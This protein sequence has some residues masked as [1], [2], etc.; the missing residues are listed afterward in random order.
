MKAFTSLL[1]AASLFASSGL[2]AQDATVYSTNKT[3]Y[4]W[5]VALFGLGV[6]ATVAG[7]AGS[8]ASNEPSSFSH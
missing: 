1:V 5:L 2:H 6:A 8:S 7:L 4:S 3:Y